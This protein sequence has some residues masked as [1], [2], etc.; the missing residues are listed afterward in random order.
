M[1]ALTFRATESGRTYRVVGREVHQ[2]GLVLTFP[3]Q[4]EARHYASR[5]GQYIRPD[6][7]PE[8]RVTR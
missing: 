3:T 7:R 4:R 2:G 8:R 5:H 6:R 1:S